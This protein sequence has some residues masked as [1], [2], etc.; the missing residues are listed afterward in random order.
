MMEYTTPESYGSTVVNVGG[1]ATDSGLVIAG[2]MGPVTHTETKED[3]VTEWPEP[4][5][6]SYKWS[7]KTADGQEVEAEITG[8]LGPRLDRVDIMVE[9]PAFVKQI[10]A[11][12]AGTKP[13]IYQV[14]GGCVKLRRCANRHSSD[15]K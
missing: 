6:G 11:S 15:R 3:A 8:S 5:A 13:Y 14:C 4:T 7:G 9:V 1:L 2:P 10:I 12:A